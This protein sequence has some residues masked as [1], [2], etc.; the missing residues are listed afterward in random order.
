V[1]R[2]SVS[3]RPI[4]RGGG[5]PLPA[6][7]MLGLAVVALGAVI[8]YASTGQLG[9]VVS[10]FGSSLSGFITKFTASAAP[11]A[12]PVAKLSGSPSLVPPTEAYTNNPMV[13]L[14]GAIPSEVAGNAA[15][16]IRIYQNLKDQPPSLIR[17]LPVGATPEFTVPGVI[18]QKGVDYFT[19]TLVGPG[20]ETHPSPAVQYVYDT[21]KPKIAVTAPLN[22]ATING[23]SVTI[24]GTTQ[25]RTVVVARNEANG[26][27]ATGTAGPD[28]TFTITL[29][30]EAGTN[31][32]TLTGTD[33]AGNIGTS[34]L[35]VLRGSGV[36]TASLTP[37]AYQYRA[38]H[39]PQPV[40]LTALVT[41]PNGHPVN[42]A[43]VTFT[44]SIPGIAPITQ[45]TTT[46]GAGT[47]VFQT[48]VPKG[49]TP[50]N[51]L[52][53]ILVTAKHLGTVSAR[54]VIAVVP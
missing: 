10:G 23:T 17:E 44:L 20:G 50:G 14:S 39:L 52:A 4:D 21:S 6:R 16:K 51:G 38:S 42:G 9:K 41:D 3:H 47:A 5:L 12:S 2:N 31:G 22:N 15:Y 11:S 19:A 54:A 46:D 28:G 48:T 45:D 25:S 27:S 34:I 18:L 8:L 30:L 7:L 24:T 33:P 36:L 29:A 43:T 26:A 32:I 35:S 40:T 1:P 49:A 13:D 53:T 37:S